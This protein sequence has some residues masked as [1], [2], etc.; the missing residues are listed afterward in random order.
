ML[1]GRLAAL[2]HPLNFGR[3][4]VLPD[5]EWYDPDCCVVVSSGITGFS[6]GDVVVLAPDHGAYYPSMSPDGREM[7]M[8]G[9]VKPWWESVLGK[10]TA[11]GFAPAPG[12]MLVER[13]QTRT[14]LPDTS[15]TNQSTR[16]SS[17]DESLRH[18][19]NPQPRSLDP[20]RMTAADS[21]SATNGVTLLLPDTFDKFSTVA[22]VLASCGEGWSRPF[23]GERVCID[24]LRTFTFR[25]V[26]PE[27][28]ALVKA[29]IAGKR[30][31]A[32]L[33]KSAS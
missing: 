17:L 33:S 28:W 13:E 29:P 8:V 23:E 31:L 18:G 30:W 10:L 3:S 2:T 25:E 32:S 26:L 5:R 22:T 21:E 14:D 24:G 15:F 12:W 1:P 11:D 27:S 6:L 7:R 16:D 20:L 19:A 4:I 9:V